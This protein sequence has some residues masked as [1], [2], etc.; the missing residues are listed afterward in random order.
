MSFMIEVKAHN[1]N[2]KIEEESPALFIMRN[3]GTNFKA[4]VEAFD[5]IIEQV[6]KCPDEE[7]LQLANVCS[8]I[9]ARAVEASF[10]RANSL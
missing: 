4:A 5:Y 1:P 3:A 6:N 9:A 7:H 2:M 8:F 10:R